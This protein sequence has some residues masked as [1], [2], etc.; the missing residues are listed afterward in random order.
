[1]KKIFL[2]LL[3][4]LAFKNYSQNKN[5]LIEY[6]LITWRNVYQDSTDIKELQK[7]PRLEFKTDS[8]G[9][10]R[11][12]TFGNKYLQHQPLTG[13]F[14]IECQKSKYRVSVFNIVFHVNPRGMNMGVLTYQ[15]ETEFTI[16]SGFLKS[17]G[18]IRKSFWG[19]NVTEKLN[20]HLFELFTIKK[21]SKSGW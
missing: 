14:K 17:D 6:N 12:T 7:D 3:M 18:T 4:F 8:T 9:Y 2:V 10:I 20:P 15:H 11:K 1:M 16:E 21:I 13:E 5:F 19:F